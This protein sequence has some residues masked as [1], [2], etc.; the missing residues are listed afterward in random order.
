ME[1]TITVPKGYNVVIIS[2]N[3]LKYLN[4]ENWA[5]IEEPTISQVADFCDC[6]VRTIKEDLKKADCPLRISTKGKR[7]RG[8]QTMFHKFTVEQYK[9]HKQ[10]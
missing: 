9:K 1:Q 5:D 7:G 10:G 2:D 8:A 6:S 4:R 3:V